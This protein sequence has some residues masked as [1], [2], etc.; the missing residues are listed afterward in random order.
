MATKSIAWWLERSPAFKLFLL[1][2]GAAIGGLLIGGIALRSPLVLEELG[3]I[4]ASY[5]PGCILM[6]IL[7]GVSNFFKRPIHNS[8]QYI[9]IGVLGMVLTVLAAKG[10]TYGLSSRGLAELWSPFMAGGVLLL[11]GAAPHFLGNVL[12][13]V[14]TIS[15]ALKSFLGRPKFR[16][17]NWL[18]VL[19]LCL[20]TLAFLFPPADVR[21]YDSRG[22]RAGSS[23]LHSAGFVSIINI[24]GDVSIRYP[25]WIVELV[26]LGSCA[27][28]ASLRRRSA[29]EKEH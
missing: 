9:T 19:L 29:S 5:A 4:A 3:K 1:F 13:A 10:G 27:L 12:T 8:T 15:C 25:Q 20:L 17:S 21:V 22:Q 6:A 16:H 23:R 24:G 14:W 2:V 7:S 18:F 28:W 11:H 26:F